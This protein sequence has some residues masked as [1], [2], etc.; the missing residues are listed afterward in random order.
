MK[1][2]GSKRWMLRNGLGHLIQDEIKT[3][4]RFVDLFSGSG[5]VAHFAATSGQSIEVIAYDLQLFSVTL[6]QSVIARSTR[7]DPDSI[8]DAWLAR[9]TKK[10]TDSCRLSHANRDTPDLRSGFTQKYVEQVRCDCA[11]EDFGPLTRAYG[12]YYFSLAQTLWLDALRIT[13]PELESERSVALA[14]LIHAASQC[15]ASPGHTAQPF[16]PSIGA[17]EFLFDAWQR[18]VRAKTIGA[19]NH[20]CLLHAGKIGRAGVADA[21]VAAEHIRKGDLVFL[22]PPYSGVHYSRFYHVLETVAQGN[23][24][25]VSGTGRY[26]PAEERPRSRYSVGTEAA[27][28][29]EGLLRKIAEKDARAILTFPQRRCSNGLSG[30][31]VHEIA[32]KFFLVTSTFKRSRFSTLGGTKNDD[33]DGYGRKARQKTHELILTLTPR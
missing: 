33:G 27:S 1:Y 17:K 6:A 26:P 2:M 10:L 22:D 19:L 28:A 21:N 14:A 15:A 23:C 16:S 32:S 13:L 30:S 20:L 31:M 18:S 5:V 29:L 3:A 8:R 12:G 24:G 11:A 9:A 7:L 25:E 4:T